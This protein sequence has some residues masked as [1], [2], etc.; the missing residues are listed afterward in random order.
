[1]AGRLRELAEPHYEDYDQEELDYASTCDRPTEQEQKFYEWFTENPDAPV[2]EVLPRLKALSRK[3]FIYNTSIGN[4]RE[5]LRIDLTHDRQYA[6]FQKAEAIRRFMD[7][8]D[9]THSTGICESHTAGY[10]RLSTYGYFEHPI[11][12]GDLERAESDEEWCMRKGML[13]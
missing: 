5:L 12:Q 10:G 8:E 9:M 3:S 11:S 6:S 4:L 1:M 2:S 13:P 7:G